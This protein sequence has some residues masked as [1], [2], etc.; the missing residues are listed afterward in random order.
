MKGF[1]SMADETRVH[2][3]LEEVFRAFDAL[4]LQDFEVERDRSLPREV[5]LDMTEAEIDEALI[6]FQSRT[7]RI[8]AKC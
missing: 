6:Y 5:D 1:E 3:T 2:P 7:R 8:D 4:D